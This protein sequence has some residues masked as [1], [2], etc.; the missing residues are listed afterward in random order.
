MI[1]MEKKQNDLPRPKGKDKN[2]AQLST[3]WLNGNAANGLKYTISSTITEAKTGWKNLPDYVF[4]DPTKS[5]ESAEQELAKGVVDERGKATATLSINTGKTAPGMLRGSIVTN[6]YEPSGEFSLDV[7][8]ALIAP[9]NC[10]VGVK[11]PK[12]EGQSH[13]NTDEDHTFSVAS[14]DKEGKVQVTV[15]E[16]DGRPMAYTLAIVDEGLLDLTHFKTPDA[17]NVFNAGE[18][19]I[20]VNVTAQGIATQSK[21]QKVSNGFDLAL[22]YSTETDQPLSPYKL[23]QSTTFKASLVVRNTSGKDLEHVAVTHILPA[24]WEILSKLPSGNVSFQDQR[25]DRMLTYIDRL[26]NGESLN[27]KFNLSAAYAGQYYL[28]SVHAEAMYDATTSGCT[29]SGECEVVGK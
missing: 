15:S 17:W 9:N 5:F 1:K 26:R 7:T 24:G 23:A 18:A 14:V 22:S 3:E 20:F 4:D 25:D 11:A 21:V 16:K 28:P 6:V 19:P 8:Q 12:Q 10:F 27:I 13:L 29:E 2:S